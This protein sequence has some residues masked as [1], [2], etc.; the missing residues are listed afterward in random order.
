MQ[1][2]ETR[3]GPNKTDKIQ[4]SKGALKVPLEQSKTFCLLT[5]KL[6]LSH[7]RYPV[8]PLTVVQS[9]RCGTL[10][11]CT[12]LKGNRSRLWESPQREIGLGC[13]K[14]PKGK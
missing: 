11:T 10:G 2:V 3:K 12:L 7:L 5:L 14:V 9:L 6:P 1:K 13:G 8:R 4:E